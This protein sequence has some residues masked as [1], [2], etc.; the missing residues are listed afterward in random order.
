MPDFLLLMHR[1]ST[2]RE[3]VEDWASYIDQLSA[4]GVLRGGSV[5][6]DGLCVR[7]EPPAPATT[8]H[9]VGYV[10]VEARDLDHAVELVRGNPVYEA[11][12]TVE[13]RS[14]PQTD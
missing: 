4:K 11:G 3:T 14:L 13:V 9:L 1:D 10:K 6:G 5:I 7:R 2:D 12:G 8:D